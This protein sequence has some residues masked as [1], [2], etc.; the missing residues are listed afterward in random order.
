MSYVCVCNLTYV[1]TRQCRLQ[2]SCQIELRYANGAARITKGCKQQE[3]CEN[4]AAGNTNNCPD[5]NGQ[6]YCVYCCQG[7]GC[8]EYLPA[9]PVDGESLSTSLHHTVRESF[10][11]YEPSYKIAQYNNM[12]CVCLHDQIYTVRH[13]HM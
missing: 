8:N 3:A 4:N 10:V 2:E 7:D 1:L 11:L 6:S 12:T 13:G 5:Q 9:N